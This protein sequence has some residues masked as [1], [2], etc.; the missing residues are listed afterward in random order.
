ML[1]PNKKLVK[2]F[3]VSA[4]F[5]AAICA[6]SQ[7][8]SAQP[9]MQE[10]AEVVQQARVNINQADAA[11]LAAALNG[12]GESKAKAIV[13][14][15]EQHGP[16]TSVEELSEVKGIGQATVNMNREKITLE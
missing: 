16:F 15:R 2:F 14:Y 12:V 13:E 8:A 9:V 3:S 7:M 10:K 6:G 5:I 4:L 11:T 1:Q